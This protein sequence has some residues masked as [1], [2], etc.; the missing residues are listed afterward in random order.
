[1]LSEEFYYYN[2]SLGRFR[3]K[4]GNEKNLNFKINIRKF[5]FQ[6]EILIDD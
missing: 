2:I 4:G 3:E 5:P 1:M 6:N